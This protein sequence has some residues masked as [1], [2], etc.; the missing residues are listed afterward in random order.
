MLNEKIIKQ[1]YLFGQNSTQR[2]PCRLRLAAAAK[3]RCDGAAG[4]L[5]PL[6]ARRRDANFHSWLGFTPEWRCSG[7]PRWAADS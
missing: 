2:L 7:G 6:R 5:F 4:G 3:S 1:N